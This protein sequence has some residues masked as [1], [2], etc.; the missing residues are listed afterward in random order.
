MYL[1]AVELD[2]DASQFLDADYSTCATSCIKHQVHELTD[3]HDDYGGF[4]DTYC[5]ENTRIDQLWWDREQVDYQDLGRQLSIEVVSVSTI[6]QP[7]G[8]VIPLHRDMFHKISS[9]YPD[10]RELKVRANIF[11]GAYAMGQFLQYIDEKQDFVTITN[12]R[13]NTGFMWD[14]DVLHVTANGGFDYKY[15]L[16]VSGFLLD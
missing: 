8:C 12:W 15:T 4:P 9:Q 5:F 10:R 13:P 16:Q 11:L 7:P 3:I 1:R 2:L 6:R 14:S